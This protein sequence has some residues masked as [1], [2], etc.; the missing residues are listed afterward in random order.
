[1]VIKITAMTTEKWVPCTEEL[2]LNPE[3]VKEWKV[4]VDQ[5]EVRFI[6]YDKGH[7]R[8]IVIRNIYGNQTV[9]SLH[10]HEIQCLIEAQ[11]QERFIT[12]YDGDDYGW[13][14]DSLEE[15]K[16]HKKFSCTHIVKLTY[17]GKDFK[18]ECVW[19]KES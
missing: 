8:P 15:A 1:M 4:D 16:E 5:R 2:A 6:A 11:I 17:D 9:S 7:E 10:F 3:R 12:F 14:Y 18:V 19:T 13:F